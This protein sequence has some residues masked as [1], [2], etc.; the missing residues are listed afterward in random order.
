M[1]VIPAFL[2]VLGLAIAGL[3]SCMLGSTGSTAFDITG[4]VTVADSA[5]WADL[6]L[7]VFYASDADTDPNCFWY[8]DTDHELI[9]DAYVYRAGYWNMDDDTMYSFAPEPVSVSISKKSSLSGT[10][11]AKLPEG[12]FDEGYYYVIAW[13]D[14]DGDGLL[15]LVDS[16]LDAEQIAFSEFNRCPRYGGGGYYVSHFF[17]A[18]G[19]GYQFGGFDGANHT[20]ALSGVDTTDFSFDLRP[21][22]SGW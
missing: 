18:A 3:T 8:F 10:F 17:H 13:L 5:D 11:G 15:D 16:F 22:I 9:P 6:R 20:A 4:S 1:K 7:G 21:A 12:G 2:L 19:S 14:A